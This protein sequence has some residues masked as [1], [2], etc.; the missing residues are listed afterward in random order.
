VTFALL[1]SILGCSIIYLR[2]YLVA[3]KIC[4]YIRNLIVAYKSLAMN[5]DKIVKQQTFPHAIQT[6]WN[7]ISNGSEISNWFLKADFKPEVG[8]NYTF[9][10]P[11]PH[12]KPIIGTVLKAT[13]YTLSY[14]WI[15]KGNDVETTVEWTL[16]TL[17][18]GY[19]QLTLVH[20]G[21]SNYEG[22]KASEMMQ[23]FDVGWNNCLNGL[24]S[25]LSKVV[26]A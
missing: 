12:C 6:V 14:T 22:I 7:A 18:N 25:H 4:I 1:Y 10:S 23:S 2:N 20:S 5:S 26:H 8:Y 9:L 21:I 16:E 24:A 19:T 13:P 15:E 17:Q 11:D 3:L